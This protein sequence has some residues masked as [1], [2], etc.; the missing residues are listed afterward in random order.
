MNET[1]ADGR[2]TASSRCHIGSNMENRHRRCLCHSPEY[3]GNS[4]R[5]SVKSGIIHNPVAP[6]MA[7]AFAR[8]TTYNLADSYNLT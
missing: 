3:P 8:V 5:E 4:F 7:L 1:F 6:A 2:D